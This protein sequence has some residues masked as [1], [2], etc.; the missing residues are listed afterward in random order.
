MAQRQAIS[1]VLREEWNAA[2]GKHLQ[3]L[4][5]W[6]PARSIGV[7][8]PM[9]SEPD[10]RQLFDEWTASGVQLALPVVIDPLLPLK[11]LAWAP[12]DPLMKDAM[13]VWVPAKACGELEPELLLIPCVGYNR[14]KFRLGYG[15][16]FYDR[17]L[18][19]SPRPRA[20][21]VAYSCS[22]ADFAVESHDIALDAVVTEAGIES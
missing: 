9:R 21:G 5:E 19:S 18:A 2:I 3:H 11:F 16:G 13:G 14:D 20:I 15:G 1:S 22:R 7:F 12:G 8:W 10:L 17:T 6:Q 4:L